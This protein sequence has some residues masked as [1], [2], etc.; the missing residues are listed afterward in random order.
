MSR[1]RCMCGDPDCPS[2]GAAMGTYQSPYYEQHEDAEPRRCDACGALLAPGEDLVC[3]EC[4][5]ATQSW[6]KE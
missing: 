1:E 3:G 5:N 4:L 2:C 6:R